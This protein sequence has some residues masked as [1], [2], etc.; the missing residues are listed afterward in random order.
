MEAIEVLSEFGAVRTCKEVKNQVVTIVL[1]DGF[2]VNA[3]RSMK[4]INRCGE[5]FPDYPNLETFITDENLAI[6]VLTK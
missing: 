3:I 2:S 1:T 5:L 6:V 4:F